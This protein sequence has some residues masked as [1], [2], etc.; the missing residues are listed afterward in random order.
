MGEQGS[1]LGK[2]R[3]LRPE[4]TRRWHIAFTATVAAL[5]A[6]L[7]FTCLTTLRYRGQFGPGPGF[8]PTWASLI[9]LILS[10][11]LHILSWRGKYSRGAGK[12]ELNPVPPFA[13][14]AVMIVSV[15]L[16]P[17]L[18]LLGALALFF[19]VAAIW[20]ER[21]PVWQ[22]VSIGILITGSMYLLFTLMNVAIPSGVFGLLLDLL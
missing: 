17:V 7:L 15:L 1:S 10:I 11:W 12:V 5:A 19:M 18:G 21:C 6:L 8:V 14:L 22:A 2:L 13:F 4:S 9:L 3:T 20:V 16:I